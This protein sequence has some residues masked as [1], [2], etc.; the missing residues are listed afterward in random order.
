MRWRRRKSSATA[1]VA[2]LLRSIVVCTFVSIASGFVLLTT[3]GA[4]LGSIGA[5]VR[6]R[7][8]PFGTCSEVIRERPGI[9]PGATNN[10]PAEAGSSC[11][12]HLVSPIYGALYS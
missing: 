8:T 11:R 12:G 2:S 1:A 7:D 3:V 10:K 6:L 5:E 4:W 9:N